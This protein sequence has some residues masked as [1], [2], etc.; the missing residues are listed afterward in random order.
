VQTYA[1]SLSPCAEL[2]LMLLCEG[3]AVLMCEICVLLCAGF[4]L[5]QV[6]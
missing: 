4:C 2:Q 5:D 6:M 1:L 3:G